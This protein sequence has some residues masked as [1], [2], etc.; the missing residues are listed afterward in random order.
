[1]SVSFQSIV[2]HEVKILS[3]LDQIERNTLTPKKTI[4]A[5]KDAYGIGFVLKN[6]F[7]RVESPENADLFIRNDSQDHPLGSSVTGVYYRIMKKKPYSKPFSD[8][9]ECLAEAM[10]PARL[11]DNT[12]FLKDHPLAAELRQ[13]LNE[14]SSKG[15]LTGAKQLDFIHFE[16]GVCFQYALGKILETYGIPKEAGKFHDPLARYRMIEIFFTQTSTPRVG[17]LVVYIRNPANLPSDPSELM[18]FGVYCA[19]DLIESKWGRRAVY[20]HRLFYVPSGYGN[21]VRYYRLKDG[22]TPEKLLE[23]L[24]RTAPG[25]YERATRDGKNLEAVKEIVA[26]A[27]DNRANYGLHDGL[28]YRIF[29]DLAAHP[30]CETL[31]HRYVSFVIDCFF[32]ADGD[33]IRKAWKIAEPIVVAGF[34]CKEVLNR[35]RKLLF[36][37]C[38][39]DDQR[40]ILT[41]RLLFASK[42]TE[43]QQSEL[44]HLLLDGLKSEQLEYRTKT[45]SVIENCGAVAFSLNMNTDQ[46][47]ALVR[48]ALSTAGQ[49]GAV[50]GERLLSVLNRLITKN[51]VESSLKSFNNEI[52]TLSDR[53][54]NTATLQT[55]IDLI[56]LL[57]DHAEGGKRDQL[58]RQ[59]MGNFPGKFSTWCSIPRPFYQ[60]IEELAK[61]GIFLDEIRQVFKCIQLSENILST[62]ILSISAYLNGPDSPAEPIFIY[63]L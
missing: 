9:P 48:E 23:E 28:S 17:D 58:L 46:E 61:S 41:F 37:S 32:N 11:E 24:S 53:V 60:C 19:E 16:E 33:D 29:K 35:C 3:L 13:R 30:D 59:A 54:V 10:V 55:L 45:L 51:C 14:T 50:Y 62:Y 31:M 38:D 57:H 15:L 25:Y 6:Y 26:H 39:K 63:P 22:I 40:L 36:E 12:L 52:L 49:G 43:E 21:H 44:F 18:H 7:K 1:M 20:K 8:I 2:N 34:G 56:I 27:L 47:N 4:L 42:I 5:Q